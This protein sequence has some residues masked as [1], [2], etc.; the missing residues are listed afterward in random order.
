MIKSILF[1]LDPS[2]ENKVALDFAAS[3]CK[4]TK[5]K[6]TGLAIVDEPQITAP[7]PAPP[8]A[9]DL[10]A[11]AVKATLEEANNNA[12]SLKKSF[13]KT[14]D[15][16]KIDSQ[17]MILS[18]DPASEIIRESHKHD[19]VILAKK[20]FYKYST[21]ED[22]CASLDKILKES[23]RPSIIAKNNSD[24][25]K[26]VFAT[27][28]SQ[29]SARAI[30]LFLSLGISKK[31]SICILSVSDKK[32][33]SE[34]KAKLAGEYIQKYGF[35]PKVNA[36][37]SSEKAGNIILSETEKFGADLLVIGAF[38]VTGLKEFFLGS[39]TKFILENSSINIFLHH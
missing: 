6:L 28:G 1:P 4:Q 33:I 22:A 27:D 31:A 35:E 34:A 7:Q 9:G 18:G 36:I 25:K 26:V 14:A 13:E 17:G 11:R 21:Q 8:G 3:L 12:K 37:E 39:V 5:T 2:D 30:Q 29:G 38:G 32:A 15:N 24:I 10:H 23:P 16:S 19:L 20:T